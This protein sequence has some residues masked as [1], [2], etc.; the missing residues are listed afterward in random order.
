MEYGAGSS[1]LMAFTFKTVFKALDCELHF[2][3]GQHNHFLCACD[4]M[5]I[6]P[7]LYSNVESIR[8]HDNKHEPQPIN[9]HQYMTNVYSL[10]DG[11]GNFSC[12]FTIYYIKNAWHQI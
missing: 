6:Q 7:P 1:F 12:A 9:K 3:R 4:Y 11:C 5:Y 8:Q 2:Y 10:L